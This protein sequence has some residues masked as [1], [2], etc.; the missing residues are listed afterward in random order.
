MRRI[1]RIL[2]IML[3]S[4]FISIMFLGCEKA[5]DKQ[6]GSV[7]TFSSFRD[8]PGV[9]DD[10]IKAIEA[11]QKQNIS[12]VYGMTPS[13]ESFSTNGKIGGFSVL[14]CEWLTGLFE[15]RFKPT[16]YE[17]GDLIAGLKTCAIDFSGDLSPTEERQKIYF[18]TDIIALRTLK[19]I[20]IEGSPP[21]SEIAATRTLR[22]IF[23]DGSTTYDHVVS[24]KAYDTFKALFAKN[25]KAAY[26]LL[27]SGKADALIAENSVEA[28]FDVYGDVVAENFFPLIFSPVSMTTQNPELTPIISVIQKA[29]ENDIIRYLNQ[30]Y[31]QGYR[32]YMKHKLF[33]QLS[34][35][36]LDFLDANSVIPFAAEYDNYP[37]SFYN[38]REKEWH[39]ICFDVLREVETLTGL[40][41][42]INHGPGKEWSEL[43]G[44]LEN[45]EV[46]ILSEL[47]RTPEREGRFLWP[48]SSFLSDHSALISRTDHRN[49]NIDEIFYVKV[50]LTKNLAH[51]ELFRR[52]FPNHKNTVE[53]ESSD[54]ALKALTRGEVDMVMNKNNL[55]LQLTHYQELPGYKANIMFDNKFKSTFGINKDKAVLCSIVDKA[56]GLI[57]TETISGQWLRRTYDY[58][59]KLAQARMPWII[60]T[61][62]ALVLIL[63]F[64]TISYMRNTKKNK[65]IAEQTSV[66]SAIYNSMPAMVFTKDLDNRYTSCNSRFLKEM[67]VKESDVI[68]REFRNINIALHNR[69]EPSEFFTTDQK[70]LNENITI[71]TEGWYDLYQRK[72]RIATQ[73][74][75]TPLIQD[76]KVV[77]LLGIAIDITERK[78]AEEAANKAHERTNI[79]INNLPGMVFQQLYNPP[80]YTYTFVSKGCKELTGYTA[81]ELIGSNAVN[82]IDIVHPDD[83]DPVEKLSEK[84]LPKGLPFEA[85]YRIITKDNTI[86]WVWERSRVIEKNPDGTP[87]LLEGYH[88]DITER[89]QLEAAEMA[90]RAKSAFLANMSHE[91]RTPMNVIVGLTDLMLEEDNP[92][93]NLKDNLRKISTAGNT[94]L[95]LINDVLDISKIEAGRLELKPVEYEMPSLLNDIIIL[96]MIRIESK[97]LAFRLDI[98]ENLPCSLYGDD[99]RIKQIINNLLSNAF[100]Y[101]QKGTVTLGINCEHGDADDV[102]MSVYVSDTGIGIRREDLNK[103]F[104]DYNQVDIQANR[105]IEGTG[106]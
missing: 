14:L 57:D 38:T 32:E 61:V 42:K 5:S 99:L 85:T 69:N 12:F 87:H 49:I 21:L 13:T 11:L 103:L 55:L 98:N 51:T 84:T 65:T 20:R 60:G 27:K 58:R 89:R 22:L 45:G 77:G 90:N 106:L 92:T 24:S 68:G 48:N 34:K 64:L 9:T 53:Y 43:I 50:G 7:T 40:K 3:F 30:L 41:F 66:L 86:K 29:L 104:A 46:H 70:I 95:G 96:N 81:E 91:M 67:N 35:E 88:T 47:I 52:W 80:K 72:T 71:T 37:V 33:M 93:V 10:E 39:G 79:I 63:V 105:R 17:W 100:K 78:L 74:I 56:L 54:T 73:I 102:W 44:M 94:L 26:D 59:T 62:A 28:N 97:P 18:M 83:L 75:K 82:F 15:I 16:I 4:A 23:F 1:K 25:K 6:S 101:T 2:N 76:D 31:N 36:E 8:I 19:Y